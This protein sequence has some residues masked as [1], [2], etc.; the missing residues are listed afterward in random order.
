MSS[1]FAP[2][3]AVRLDASCPCGAVTFG[4]PSSFVMFRLPPNA[5]FVSASTPFRIADSAGTTG[6][7]GAQLIGGTLEVGGVDMRNLRN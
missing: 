2:M 6:P 4:V 1:F 3:I 7:D 5:A